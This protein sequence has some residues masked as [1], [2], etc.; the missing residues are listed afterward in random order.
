MRLRQLC[1][2]LFLSFAV[3]SHADQWVRSEASGDGIELYTK[4]IPGNNFKNFKGEVTINAP[5][6]TVL[7]VLMV[8]DTYTKWWYNMLQVTTLE[9][10][11]PGHSL[12][13][14]WIKGVWPTADRDAVVNNEVS[15]D[16]QTL[17]VVFHSRSADPNLMPA[18]D[19]RVRLKD[20]DTIIQVE[21]VSP[22]QTKVVIEGS[23]N[24]GGT[25]PSWIANNFILDT[26]RESLKNLRKLVEDKDHPVDLGVLSTDL[27]AKLHM[28]EI[29]LPQ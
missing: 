18:F 20:V 26:P 24:P 9:K 14:Y 27:F 6:K 7:A 11:N 16:P 19:S 13:Y 23:G 3:S 22:S 21:P 2:V 17:K 29:R 4:A 12:A 10:D 25:V 28:S 1:C 8:R 5:M 15:Q